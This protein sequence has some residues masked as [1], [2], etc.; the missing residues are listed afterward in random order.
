[1][2]SK[3]LNHLHNVIIVFNS[4]KSH[5]KK[6]RAAA[7]TLDKHAITADIGTAKLGSMEWLKISQY[8]DVPVEELLNKQHPD[9]LAYY[10]NSEIELD[11]SSALK[12]L[13]KNPDILKYPIGIYN[14][15]A[16]FLRSKNEIY[17]LE[18]F[19]EEG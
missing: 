1:M 18:E 3:V 6:C 9:F 2:S 4:H 16:L 13:S 14:K 8:L 10:G 12:I 17:R 15:K 11:D 7:F 19:M 5:D